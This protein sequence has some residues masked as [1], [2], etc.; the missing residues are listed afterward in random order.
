MTAS[1]RLPFD[2]EI[3]DNADFYGNPDEDAAKALAQEMMDE[4]KEARK[5]NHK[6]WFKKF[7]RDNV[8]GKRFA[9]QLPGRR[10]LSGL[11]LSNRAQPYRVVA[12][13]GEAA[14][15][16]VQGAEYD[17]NRMLTANMRRANKTLADVQYYIPQNKA[18]YD[19]KV[20]KKA[21][22]AD[23]AK[24]QAIRE[25]YAQ[26]KQLANELGVDVPTPVASP[27]PED[28]EMI[29][30]PADKIPTQGWGWY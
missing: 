27:P 30:E 18:A 26:Y 28:E 4:L 3:A 5:G 20:A 14:L 10:K 15:A 17:P 16:A 23:H 22:D 19:A 2:Q 6:S 13:E 9:D 21:A 24:A 11:T 8:K 1:I 7:Y 12:P 25:K 29:G